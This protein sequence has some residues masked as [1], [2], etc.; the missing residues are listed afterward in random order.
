VT[1]LRSRRYLIDKRPCRPP[2]G[3]C[4]LGINWSCQFEGRLAA[5]SLRS[6]HA[7]SRARIGRATELLALDKLSWSRISA[8]P[9]CDRCRERLREQVFATQASICREKSW[10]YWPLRCVHAS[11]SACLL[12]RSG[13]CSLRRTKPARGL[14]RRVQTSFA[15]LPLPGLAL[16]D[17]DHASGCNWQLRP[18]Q[19]S[20]PGAV[21]AGHAHLG[22]VKARDGRLRENSPEAQGRPHSKTCRNHPAKPEVQRRRSNG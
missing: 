9:G 2:H 4:A 18:H 15:P 12:Q 21:C 8:H 3:R 17:A 1:N 16:S 6:G 14:A 22:F 19:E 11:R 20:S 7:L 13:T 10:T 5:P